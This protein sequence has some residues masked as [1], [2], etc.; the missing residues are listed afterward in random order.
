MR[1]SASK[2]KATYPAR[3]RFGRHGCPMLSHLSAAGGTAKV[4]ADW[5]FVSGVPSVSPYLKLIERIQRKKGGYGRKS[6]NRPQGPYA[7]TGGTGAKVTRF[8]DETAGAGH[9]RDRWDP[10]TLGEGTR[11]PGTRRSNLGTYLRGSPR[12]QAPN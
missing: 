8:F 2:T 3:V 5:A 6:I 1:G 10:L 11:V 7:E 9:R 4:P 12:A